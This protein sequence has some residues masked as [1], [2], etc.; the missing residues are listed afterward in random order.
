MR[1]RALAS[2]FA[3]CCIGPL[4]AGERIAVEGATIRYDGSVAYAEGD[5]AIGQDANVIRELL[6]GNPDISKI[7]LVGDFP[8]TGFALEVALVIEAFGLATEIADEC[9]NACIYMF[10][11]GR[12]RVLGDGARMGMRR[13]VMD[14]A[15]LRKA[16]PDDAQRYGWA[17]EFGQGAMM[18][19]RGQSD[20]R[21][22]LLHLVQQGI[23]L[24]FALKIFATPRE[25]MWWPTR[26]E[27]IA[28][29]V[30]GGER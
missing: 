3:V 10:A 18:Y 26:E 21:W 23:S 8:M 22:A 28:G 7:V 27:L 16:Y 5:N 20:M 12:P 4:H 15:H 14:A 11:A 24:D 6:R 25:D 9:T 17:D 2:V 19:D 30:I 1:I 13:R 29:G